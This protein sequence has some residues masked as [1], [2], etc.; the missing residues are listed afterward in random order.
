M[1]IRHQFLVMAGWLL[2]CMLG[3]AWLSA[4]FSGRQPATV[5][6]DVGLSIIRLGLPLIGLLLLQD[7]LAKEFDRRFFLLSLTYPRTRTMFLLGRALAVALLLLLLLCLA[8]LLLAAFVGWQ[9]HAYEQA[10]P[11]ALG[12]P[13][14]L[15][16]AFTLVD[17]FV[18]MAVG[19]LLAVVVATPSFVLVGTLGFMLLARSF[20]SIMAL[21]QQESWLV[22]DAQSYHASLGVLGYLIP[23]LAVLDIRQIALYGHWELLAAEWPRQVL[24]ALVYGSAVLAL[25]VWLLMRRRFA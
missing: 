11:V 25:A 14:W 9:A 3:A 18:V 7:L 19:T 13:Y 15:T 5:A 2:V 23:D 21:L 12:G 20:S 17:L 8:A 10:T 16:L 4:E 24:T 22:A 1:A 6:L